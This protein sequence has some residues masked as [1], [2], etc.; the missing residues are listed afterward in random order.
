M[1]LILAEE[2][3]KALRTFSEKYPKTYNILT[4]APVAFE[5]SFE[6]SSIIG[7][8]EYLVVVIAGEA[9]TR[10]WERTLWILLRQTESPTAA[11]GIAVVDDTEKTTRQVTAW[12]YKQLLGYWGQNN[13]P[14]P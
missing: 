9:P 1:D 3:V 4:T 12:I 14:I 13:P 6:G 11:K 8:P 7:D 5:L 10:N 2:M